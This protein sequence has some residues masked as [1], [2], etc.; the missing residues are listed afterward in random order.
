MEDALK[1]PYLQL[2]HDPN[3]EPVS[4]KIPEDFF[5]FDKRK[6]ELTIEELKRMLYDEI[7][8]PL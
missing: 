8:K 5:D 4:E 2:Y 6:D 7:M 1:H 3:D